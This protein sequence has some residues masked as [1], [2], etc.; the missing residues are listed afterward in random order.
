MLLVFNLTSLSIYSQRQ[1]VRNALKTI[2]TGID[3]DLIR[4]NHI[5]KNKM[6]EPKY[7]RANSLNVWFIV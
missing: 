2:D 6:K 3:K 7:A 1:N 5:A 4:S